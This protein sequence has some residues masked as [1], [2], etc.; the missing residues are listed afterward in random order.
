[1]RHVNFNLKFKVEV[2]YQSLSKI[3]DLAISTP[4]E[5][6][7]F[8]FAIFIAIDLVELKLFKVKALAYLSLPGDLPFTLLGLPL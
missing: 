8:M 4:A 1:L 7:K 6:N 5:L 3:I 2:E